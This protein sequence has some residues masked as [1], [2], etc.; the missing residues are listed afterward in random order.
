MEI[1]SPDGYNSA[2]KGA[3]GFRVDFT[4]ALSVNFV[5]LAV[6]PVWSH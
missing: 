1:I 2:R 4:E 3:Q 5:D 6:L